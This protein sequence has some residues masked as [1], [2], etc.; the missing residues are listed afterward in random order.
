M[1]VIGAGETVNSNDTTT[2]ASFLNM[3]IKSWQAKNLLSDKRRV[4]YVF[5]S[6]GTV[7]YSLNNGSSN[8]NATES[9]VTTSTS[10][11]SASGATTITVDSIT[12]ISTTNK[13]G[14]QMEDD[15]LH[16]TTVNGAPSGSTVTL[17]AALTD[18]VAVDARVFVYTT[19][20]NRPV[21]IYS[22]NRRTY[23]AGLTTFSDTPI[24]LMA[25]REYWGQSVKNNDNAFVG[26]MY[27]RQRDN[28]YLYLWPG[29]D[30][31]Q[32]VAV[33]TYATTVEDFDASGD[34]PDFTQE[35]YLPLVYNL[36]AIAG[37]AYNVDLNH[38]NFIT[39]KAEQYLWDVV[40]FDSDSENISWD[41]ESQ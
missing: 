32:S 37:P 3:M 17:T 11:V 28:G 20:I 36:A 25:H 5:L 4:G 27:D 29:V 9:F 16:W 33:I 21:K 13:I 34:N 19:R 35:W 39:Q 6:N 31:P 2:M 22:V 10:A 30:N 12:G 1:Q 7:T 26:A 41:P 23:N 15:T 14:V 40:D 18:D 24:P 38:L 8:A